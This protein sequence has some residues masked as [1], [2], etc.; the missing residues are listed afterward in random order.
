MPDYSKGKI[1]RIRNSLNEKVYIGSTTK[2]LSKR[3]S[4]HIYDAYHNIPYCMSQ[5]IQEI[6][7]ENLMIELIEEYP[8][9][10]KT[11]LEQIEYFWI[12]FFI[13]LLG[14]DNV[15]NINIDGNIPTE[16]KE[17]HRIKMMGRI[18]STETR[19]KISKAKQGQ[20]LGV[21]LNDEI[22]NKMSKAKKGK[23][24]N[25]FKRGTIRLR[26]N[27]YSFDYGFFDGTVYKKTSK[28]FNFNKYGGEEKALK[29]AEK[30]RDTIFPPN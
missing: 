13:E 23:K 16:T 8:C 15:Y 4:N 11:E 21:K 7:K 26:N 12:G 27:Y 18:F 5:P 3:L 6:G 9:S 30:F 28:S 1:Y 29:E 25:N 20:K 19:E 2:K 14:R 22:K 10:S 17:K 24:S